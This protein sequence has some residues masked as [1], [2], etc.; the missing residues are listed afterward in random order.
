MS[1][2]DLYNK[3]REVPQNAQ[4][5][6]PAGR[7]KGMTDINPMWRIQ[8][9]TEQFGMCGI[10]WSYE[11]TNQWIEEGANCERIAFTNIN[12][13]VKVG[14]N[15][16]KAIPGTGGSSFISK[17]RSGLY[18][19]DECFKMSLTDAISVACKS[20]GVGADIYW[21][22]GKSK[23]TNP[24]TEQSSPQSQTISEAQ[25]KRIFA[26]AKNN[27]K[28]VKDVLSSKGYTSTSHI[29]KGKVY[30]DICAEIESKVKEV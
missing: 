2:M 17:E 28:L 4:K 21:Q 15:W 27:T 29:L 5:S 24:N 8:T 14:E 22:A 1:N 6:I 9:L 3:V 25:Q 10:G 13:Y 18:T 12:L 30:N 20:L 11:I 23:Y 16:S 7:L 26:I 19:S